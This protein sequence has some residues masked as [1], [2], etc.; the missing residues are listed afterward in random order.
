[1]PTFLY[2]IKDY[3]VFCQ[4]EWLVRATLLPDPRSSRTVSLRQLSFL[5]KPCC[6]VQCHLYFIVYCVIFMSKINDDNDDDDDETH[7]ML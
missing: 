6:P 7:P 1:M 2:R 4:E 3:S 5:Y